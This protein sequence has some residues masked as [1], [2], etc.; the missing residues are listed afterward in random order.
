MDEDGATEE[1]VIG[2]DILSA[3]SEKERW[4]S[5]EDS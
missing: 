2:E 1:A 3:F 5:N 4:S